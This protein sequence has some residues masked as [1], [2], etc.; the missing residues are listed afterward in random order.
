MKIFLTEPT[1]YIE[2]DFSIWVEEG[3]DVGVFCKETK[4]LNLKLY[5]NH[6]EKNSK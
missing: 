3:H 4:R 6:L 5:Q 1:G 2:K